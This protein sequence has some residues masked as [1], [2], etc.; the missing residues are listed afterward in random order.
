MS[1]VSLVIP[2]LPI[3]FLSR[4]LTFGRGLF[5]RVFEKKREELHHGEVS[6]SLKAPQVDAD[7][8]SQ[9][10]GALLQKGVINIIETL[11]RR[12]GRLFRQSLCR[13]K[14]I[15]R[16]KLNRR[17]LSFR[18]QQNSRELTFSINANTYSTERHSK[19]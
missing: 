6:R 3:L 11:R 16:R 14:K 8:K 12:V 5:E 4:L 10:F 2:I 1:V 17:N 9:K 18:K 13:T 15:G 7:K 19:I